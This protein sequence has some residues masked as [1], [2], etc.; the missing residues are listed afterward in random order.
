MRRGQVVHGQHIRVFTQGR[1]CGA[2]CVVHTAANFALADNRG[3]VVVHEADLPFERDHV[4]GPLTIDQVDEGRDQGGLAVARQ[5]GHQHQALRLGGQDFTRQ[6]Q[7]FGGRRARRDHMEHDAGAAVIRERDAAHAAEI[8]KL[9]EPLRGLAATN[10]FLLGFGHDFHHRGLDVGAGEWRFAVQ[11]TNVAF[12]PN[13]G[14][15]IRGHKQRGRGADRGQAQQALNAGAAH[16]GSPWRHFNANRPGHL[17]NG[18]TLGDGRRLVNHHRLIDRER[19]L[20]EGRR[21]SDD[22]QLF[23][24]RSRLLAD[25]HRF[26]HHLERRFT[27][28]CRLVDGRNG[29]RHVHQCRRHVEVHRRRGHRRH[30]LAATADLNPDVVA[31]AS[32]HHRKGVV[33]PRRQAMFDG[34]ELLKR[35]LGGRGQQL[36]QHAGHRAEVQDLRRQLLRARAHDNVR[37]LTDVHHQSVAIGA[38]HRG[39][40]RFD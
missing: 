3:A 37:P 19:F 12:D 31:P 7:L 22:G 24:N 18:G 25:Q 21:I 40:K 5:G 20:D 13:R 1:A 17:E 15:A 29:H 8:R 10:G 28:L 39:Q 26:R 11:R 36:L 23:D 6:S 34:A 16:R 14:P 35:I 4:L 9:G 32:R 27:D 33:V 30:R 38:D 2:Q